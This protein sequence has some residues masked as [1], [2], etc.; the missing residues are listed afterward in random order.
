[1]LMRL[2]SSMHLTALWSD[3]VWEVE[4]RPQFGS[5]HLHLKEIHERRS[6]VCPHILAPI[7]I[8]CG[9]ESQKLVLQTVLVP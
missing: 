4:L 7:Q 2:L 9:A 8:Y 5:S 3:L 6:V 1:M